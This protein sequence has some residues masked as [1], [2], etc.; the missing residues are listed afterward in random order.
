[1]QHKSFLCRLLK[2][3]FPIAVIIGIVATAPVFA[4]EY[5]KQMKLSVEGEA[6]TL[7]LRRGHV[8]RNLDVVGGDGQPQRT[9]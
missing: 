1:M 7:L 4:A 2:A 9:R 6:L 5:T 8:T 3:L